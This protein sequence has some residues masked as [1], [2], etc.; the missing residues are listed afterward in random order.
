M[1]EAFK[2]FTTTGAIEIDAPSPP[3]RYSTELFEAHGRETLQ[4]QR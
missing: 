3:P 2:H 4:R 1:F